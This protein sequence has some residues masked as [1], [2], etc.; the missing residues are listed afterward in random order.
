MRAGL[1]NVAP[2]VGAWIEIEERERR[3]EKQFVAPYVGAWI[4]MQS[5]RRKQ[6]TQSR[7][8]RGGVD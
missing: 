7:S 5:W 2:Y 4:E 6:D 1:I 8:L 3:S